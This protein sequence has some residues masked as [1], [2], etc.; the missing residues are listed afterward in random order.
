MTTYFPVSLPGRSPSPLV[1]STVGVTGSTFVQQIGE[2][3][4][5]SLGAPRSAMAVA[6]S[7][8]PTLDGNQYTVNIVWNLFGQRYYT[9][10]YDQNGNLVFTVALIETLPAL[11]LQTLSWNPA[12]L[13][14]TATTSAPHGYAIGSVIN[15]TIAGA[16]PSAYNGTFPTFIN[17][18]STFQYSLSNDPG[19]M[20]IPGL[21]SYM[22]SL[23]SGYFQSTMIYRS[24]QFE[25]SP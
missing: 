5:I 11:A 23:C 4:Q 25:V 1:G 7:F 2:G 21:V 10:C 14:V 12:S 17:G 13:Q 22:I 15:L 18:P 9:N 20:S 6:P 8:T 16:T 3:V 24:S 19:S